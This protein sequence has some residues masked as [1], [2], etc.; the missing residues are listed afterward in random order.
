MKPVTARSPL[1][2]VS[3]SSSFSHSQLT[4][5]HATLCTAHADLR[6]SLLLCLLRS[7]ALAFFETARAEFTRRSPS[8]SPFFH[9]S[10]AAR[11]L[12]RSCCLCVSAADQT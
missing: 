12:A 11:S 7:T 2:Q 10:T 8:A 5:K 4:P 6:F 3:S 9:I 1:H